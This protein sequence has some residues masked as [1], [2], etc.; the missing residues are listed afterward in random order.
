MV[1]HD[2]LL[3]NEI[4]EPEC[5]AELLLLV[6]DLLGGCLVRPRRRALHA[7]W[8]KDVSS[9]Q[10]KDT[11][12]EKYANGDFNYI[13]RSHTYVAVAQLNAVVVAD[14][15]AHVPEHAQAAVGVENESL[16]HAGQIARMTPIHS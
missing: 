16:V 2:A 5:E 7:T 9:Q 6:H 10:V 12:V 8:L 4:V 14:G 13:Y 1:V 3:G 11:F 15:E